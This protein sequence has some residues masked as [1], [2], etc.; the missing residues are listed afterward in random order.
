MD[1]DYFLLEYKNSY[2]DFKTA[3]NEDEAWSARR[4]MARLEQLAAEIH[5]FEFADFMHDFIINN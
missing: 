2:L 3:A 4:R 1:K 5:G